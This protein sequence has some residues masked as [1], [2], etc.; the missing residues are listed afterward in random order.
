[1]LIYGC[2]CTSTT[3]TLLTLL[4]AW[5]GIRPDHISAS[6]GSQGH[7]VPVYLSKV[8]TEACVMTVRKISVQLVDWHGQLLLLFPVL[9]VIFVDLRT[10]REL[11]HTAYLLL[12]ACYSL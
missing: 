1:M 10:S 12:A 6:L 7:N 9:S 5:R 2:R 3:T 8:I 11:H 4:T